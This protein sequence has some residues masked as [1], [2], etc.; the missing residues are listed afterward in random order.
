MRF[1]GEVLH[2]PGAGR[3][4]ADATVRA[5]QDRAAAWGAEVRFATGPAAVS[6]GGDDATVRA[7]GIEWRA[8]VVVVTAGAWLPSVVGTRVPL[9]PLAITRE[10]I[11]HF[12]PRSPDGRWPSFIHHQADGWRYGLISPGEG[13]KVAEH[14]TGPPADPDDPPPAEPTASGAGGGC[15]AARR[16]SR[17]VKEWLPGLEAT[18]VHPATCLYTTTPTHDF[19]LE[20]H[21]PIVV[22]SPCSGHGFKFTPLVGRMLAD[23]ATSAPLGRG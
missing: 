11:Q 7:A 4:L 8:P 1:E 19:V 22:G 14:M 6:W 16:V 10:Q 13:V 9:P 21:G 2:C 20:R 3:C 17:Y 23:L 5:L 12:V 18:P 15:A